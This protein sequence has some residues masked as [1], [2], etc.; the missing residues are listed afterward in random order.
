MLLVGLDPHREVLTGACR[1]EW[2]AVE[3]LEADR[4]HRIA[5]RRDGG[6]GQL[7]EAGPGGRRAGYGEARVAATGGFVEQGFERR[8]PAGAKGRDPQRLQQL[9]AR[10]SGKVEQP[11]DLRD[12]HLLGP[13]SELDDL[14]SRLYVA[15][16]EDP[17][18]EA[19]APAGNEQS[20]NPR[21]VQANPNAIAR[22]PGLRYLERRRAD[23]V[24][25]AD[26]DLVVAEPVDREVLAELSVDEVIS[27]EL[28][29]PVAVGIH[30]VDEH[31]ALLTT[32]AGQVALAVTL[33]V[34]L[35]DMARARHGVLEDSGEDGLPLPP[36]ILRHADVHRDERAYLRSGG[37]HGFS[38]RR[39]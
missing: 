34:E 30:L 38:V 31:G 10:V 14:V 1:R 6:H 7:T 3:V 4:D 16:L 18:V 11:V 27:A 33:D 9:L 25:V 5:F 35:P 36:H 24:T 39:P 26:A 28:A 17:E 13:G 37:L 21:I 22:D 2:R 23:S 8:L 15:L 29:F 32:V 12:R 19:R 20:G